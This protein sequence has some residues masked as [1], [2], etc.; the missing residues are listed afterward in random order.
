MFKNV[1]SKI[2]MLAVISFVIG[3]I[4]SVI[5]AFVFLVNANPKF[6]DALWI[7]LIM[8]LGLIVFLILAWL[9]FGYGELVENSKKMVS[10]LENTMTNKSKADFEKTQ[11]RVNE[12]LQENEVEEFECLTCK[13]K[14]TVSADEDTAECPYCHTK[15]KV[16]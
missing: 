9:L 8:V 13:K 2:K 11:Q 12:N 3:E 7:L 10:L 1:G 16:Y 5:I 15:Y 14:F 6:E 4:L